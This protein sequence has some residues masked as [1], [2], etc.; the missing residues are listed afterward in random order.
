MADIKKLCKTRTG[1]YFINDIDLVNV[2]FNDLHKPLIAVRL[3][4]S[5]TRIF[6]IFLQCFVEFLIELRSSD[7]LSNWPPLLTAGWGTCGP[8]EHLTFD[9]ACNRIF[10]TQVRL[11]HRIKTK[12][13]DKQVL[14]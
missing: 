9:M 2:T 10:V 11:Q 3:I 8:R 12:L 7:M 5:I 14:R 13:Q 6:R 4:F 1:F